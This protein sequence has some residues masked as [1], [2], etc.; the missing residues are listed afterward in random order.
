MKLIPL[1][2]LVKFARVLPISSA[3]NA[4]GPDNIKNRSDYDRLS[5]TFVT[6]VDRETTDDR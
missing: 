6:K 4:N 1:P 3:D 2:F 5:G